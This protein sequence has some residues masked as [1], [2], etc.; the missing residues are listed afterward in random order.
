MVF[1]RP[2]SWGYKR[3]QS[4][5]DGSSNGKGITSSQSTETQNNGQIRKIQIPQTRKLQC[6]RR[7]Y[8][9]STRY[10]QWIIVTSYCSLPDWLLSNAEQSVRIR[11]HYSSLNSLFTTHHVV[12]S[13]QITLLDG[14]NRPFKNSKCFPD[15]LIFPPSQGSCISNPGR[16]TGI[17]VLSPV[18]PMDPNKYVD[19]IFSDPVL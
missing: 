3:T 2:K 15:P 7:D 9:I 13:T 16:G 14:G 19:L 18:S 6:C 12:E 11:A 8:L 1:L 17:H 4:G 5:N 10:P